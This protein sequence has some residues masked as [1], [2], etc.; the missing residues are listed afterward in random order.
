MNLWDIARS[1]G[2]CTMDM[3]KLSEPS[4][5]PAGAVSKEPTQG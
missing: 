1:L 2:G 4:G 3:A 5:G